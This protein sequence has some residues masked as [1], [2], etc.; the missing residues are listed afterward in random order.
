MKPQHRC[1]VLSSL[2]HFILFLLGMAAL[3]WYAG[4]KDRFIGLFYL[5]RGPMFITL[6][7]YFY[8]LNLVGWATAKIRYINIFS[9]SSPSETPNPYVILTLLGFWV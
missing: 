7:F 1:F 9:F 3:A 8:S 5:Y 4:Y 2:I 6:Y